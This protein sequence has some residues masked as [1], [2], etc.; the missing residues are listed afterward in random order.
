MDAKNWT[1][2]VIIPVFRPDERFGLLMRR[3]QRQTYRPQ[4]ILVINTGQ[5]LWEA[6]DIPKEAFERGCTE[7]GIPVFLRH[8]A[9]EEFDHGGTRDMA[10][11]LSKADVLLFMTQD[12]LPADTHL[13]EALVRAL[14]E[15]Q[16]ESQEG[17]TAAA[18]ARQLPKEDCS[19]LERYTRAFNYGDTSLVKSAQDLPRLGVKTYFCSNVCAAYLRKVYQKLGG[20]EKQTI[21]NEDMIFCGHL[22]QAGYRIAYAADARVIHSHDYS[23]AQQFHRNFDLAVS[24]AQH[25]EVFAGVSSESEG[26]RLVKKEAADLCRSG[27]IYLLPQLIWQSACKYLGYLLGK[28]YR[29]LPRRFV[30]WCSLNK[31]Y[32]KNKLF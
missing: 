18:Y 10:A 24:Q 8:I 22:I 25:P 6:A 31:K 16:T 3:L 26:V 21:F 7:N 20:F 28:R 13:I 12:A 11:A 27:H 19:Y 32:W 29:R 23:G 9:E 1:V 5:K 15:G 14:Q 30:T 2:D 4:Q 17:C